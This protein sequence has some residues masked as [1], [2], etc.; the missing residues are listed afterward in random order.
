MHE[1]TWGLMEGVAQA[2]LALVAHKLVRQRGD[3]LCGHR[4]LEGV[5]G[6]PLP[7]PP[8]PTPPSTPLCR[9]GADWEAPRPTV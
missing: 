1:H 3:G 7:P 9:G 6:A 8:P 4:H 2:V 5:G